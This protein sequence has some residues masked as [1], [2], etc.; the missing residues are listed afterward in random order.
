MRLDP[1]WFCSCTVYP[2]HGITFV[3][4]DA[5]VRPPFSLD[6]HL[7]GVSAG[8]V[9]RFCSSKCH[10][11]FKMKRLPRKKRWTKTHRK[12]AGKELADVRHVLPIQER[13]AH[14]PCHLGHDVS[15]GAP[16]QSTRAL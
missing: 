12:L 13:C 4:N 3:R 2:G 10:K 11:S 9:F 16:T 8:Q 6:I 14:L 15:A 7:E 5:T 1:C